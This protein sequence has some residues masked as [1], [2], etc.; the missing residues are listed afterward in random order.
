MATEK[1]RRKKLRK[2]TL[3]KRLMHLYDLK[4]LFLKS[5]NLEKVLVF[6]FLYNN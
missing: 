2:I 3:L 6:T 1:K 4:S 5:Y